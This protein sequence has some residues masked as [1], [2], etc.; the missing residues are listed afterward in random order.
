MSGPAQSGSLGTV[1]HPE[2]DLETAGSHLAPPPQLRRLPRRRRPG[3]IALAVVLVGVGVLGSAALYVREN[4][5]V[6]VLMVLQP[7]PAGSVITPADIGT[8]SVA[9]GPGISLIPARQLAQV[10]GLVAATALRPGTLLSPSELTTSEPPGPGQVLVPVA[11]RPS[12]LP[13]AGLAPGDRVLVVA[14]PAVPGSNG[15]GGTGSAPILVKPVSALV[16]EVSSGPDQDG[17]DVVDLLVP[18]VSG[19]PVAQQA[20]TGEIALIVQYRSP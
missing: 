18:A 9:A 2:P 19:I 12:V 8:A 13:A 3:M 5:Q 1:F 20:A 4:H 17:L 7:V 10:T 6:Q 14:T 15:S 16:L 11:V